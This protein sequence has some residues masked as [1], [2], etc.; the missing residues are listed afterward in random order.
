MR[1]CVCEV[2]CDETSVRLLL[3]LFLCLHLSWPPANHLDLFGVW[4][5]EK[6]LSGPGLALYGI[7]I[8]V[9]VS[10]AHAFDR[11]V[12]DVI[13]FEDQKLLQFPGAYMASS[14]PPPAHAALV[15]CAAHESDN[16]LSCPEPRLHL[17]VLGENAGESR[18]PFPFAGRKGPQ[19]SARHEKHSCSG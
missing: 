11:A 3:L 18:A 16:P 19:G 4:A 12:T 14:C 9:L 2:G 15:C 17:R 1:V 5:L 8:L 10:H 7:E 6:F 13:V